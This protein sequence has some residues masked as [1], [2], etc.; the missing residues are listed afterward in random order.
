MI[1]P[2][3]DDLAKKSKKR[4]GKKDKVVNKN[5]SQVAEDKFGD[6]TQTPT[7]TNK[8]DSSR[9]PPPCLERLT[10]T[11]PNRGP[12]VVENLIIVLESVTVDRTTSQGMDN[13]QFVACGRFEVLQKGSEVFVQLVDS[14]EKIVFRAEVPP[15]DKLH[16]QV[17]GNAGYEPSFFWEAYNTAGQSTLYRRYFFHFENVG[18][19]TLAIH[20]MAGCNPDISAKEFF[21]KDGRFF[22]KEYTRP[23]H[24]MNPRED[25]MDLEDNI[26]TRDKYYSDGEVKDLFDNDP[27]AET[28]QF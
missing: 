15:Q 3:K 24:V 13:M 25:D 6:S 21:D 10:L 11:G 7:P 18:A 1:S 27:Y 14:K 8:K 19:L 17:Q 22:A 5:S 26:V 12:I 9:Q 28:Q 2:E 23:S 16:L 4:R 20:Y